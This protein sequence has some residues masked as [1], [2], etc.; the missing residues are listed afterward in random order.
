M[1]LL[2][3]LS[4]KLSSLTLKNKFLIAYSGGLD[5]HVLL[6]SMAALRAEDPELQLQAAHIHHGLSPNA[7][8]WA[9]HCKQ[10]CAEL[11]IPCVVKKIKLKPTKKDSL[12]A[13]ARE[14]RYQALAENI[15][16]DT[17]LLTAHTQTDQAETVLLQLLRGAGPKGLAA[18]P[19][20]ME[21]A[22]TVKIRPLLNFTRAALEE[23]AQQN[24]LIW[25]ED[26]SNANVAF[27][28]NYIRHEVMPLIAKR[29]PSAAQTMAR[30]AKHCAAADELFTSLAQQD[31]PTIVGNKPA[32]LSVIKL[33]ALSS[34]RQQNVL[35]YWLQQLQLPLPPTTKMQQIQTAVLAARKEAKPKVCWPGAEVRRYQ[36]NLYAFSSL[37]QHDV[38]WKAEWDLRRSLVLPN[39]MGLL[40]VEKV[41]GQGI[42]VEATKN[43]TV[44][45]RQSRERCQP[46]GRVGSHPLKKLFQE[47]EVPPWQRQRV[48]L[49]Y[50]GSQL[51][52]VVG[53]CYC[54]KFAAKQNQ[55]GFVIR[56]C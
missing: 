11:N 15:T 7:G 29:W 37:E 34:A 36:D 14:K 23:Y 45:F 32:T 6:H 47:W 22:G 35:R 18:M 38:T 40:S 49:I 27:D 50:L 2:A 9:K 33:L 54:D 20:V 16:A 44:C 55:H 10:I 46:D 1:Y 8:R 5:S 56:V 43:V 48:P 51:A 53:Y 17:C 25:I 31:L 26:E 4:Q 12:E 13:L 19:E 42:A 52:A 39:G 28:R 41:M 21:F 3:K 30:S 24:K